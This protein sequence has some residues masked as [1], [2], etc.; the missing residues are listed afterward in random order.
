MERGEI[1]ELMRSVG[2]YF[3]EDHPDHVT[4]EKLENGTIEPPFLEFDI[5][6]EA[7]RA[8]GKVY[9]R[10][11]RVNVRKFDDTDDGETNRMFRTAMDTAEVSY[12]M[13]GH[14]FDEN[15]GLWATTYT[16]TV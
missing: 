8:D 7:I 16:F 5:L 14:S 4:V 11:N 12:R 3:D 1:I 6:E 10:Y 9:E 15:L 13:T 2:L